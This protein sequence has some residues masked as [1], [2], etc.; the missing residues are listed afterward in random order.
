[1][2]H[3]LIDGESNPSWKTPEAFLWSPEVWPKYPTD[4]VFSF[5]DRRSALVGGLTVVLPDAF[6]SETPE[7]KVTAPKAVEV[8]VANDNSEQAYTKVADASIE[9]TPGDHPIT[10]PAR[11]AKFVKLRVVSGYSDKE[12][13][14]GEVRIFE[15]AR[16]GYVAL[17]ERAPEL[18]HWK[19]S[20]RQAAERGL[21]WLQLAAV[22]W[23]RTNKCAGCHVQAQALM[24]QAVA[25]KQGYRIDAGSVR[26][27]A[28][29]VRKDEAPDGT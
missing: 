15:A 5:F 1:M 10:F 12:L 20:P 16:P 22:D 2:R 7:D 13:E 14:I 23:S 24:G 18:Q 28:D 29:V 9:A 4:V 21:S 8:W 25:L 11:E 17:A 19:G 27:L 6:R 3:R 26:E